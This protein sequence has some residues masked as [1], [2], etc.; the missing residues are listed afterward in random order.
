MSERMSVDEVVE[1]TGLCKSTLYSLMDTGQ[2]DL[3]TVIRNGSKNTYVFF[4]PKVERF[5][6]GGSDISQYK[7]LVSSIKMMNMLLT[8]AI[9]TLPGGKEKLRELAGAVL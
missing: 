7:E 5:V 2:A 4:R 9:T 6:K 8:S 3:G 1:L